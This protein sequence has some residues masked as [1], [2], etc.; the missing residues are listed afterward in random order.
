SLFIDMN[1][2]DTARATARAEELRAGVGDEVA[3]T[4]A[5][6]FGCESHLE[7]EFEKVYTSF[8]LPEGRGG[9]TGSKKRYAGLVDGRLE[10]VGL[11]AVRRDWSPGARRFQRQPLERGR[12]ERPATGFVRQ[13]VVGRRAAGLQ[14]PAPVRH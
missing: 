8:L 5:S 11:E 12:R 14:R 7:L 13:V 1:E 9:A 2:P 10:I 6:D 3:A 4:L